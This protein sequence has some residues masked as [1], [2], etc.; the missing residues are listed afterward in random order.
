[1]S[2]SSGGFKTFC[3]TWLNAYVACSRTRHGRCPLDQ[4][5]SQF[6]GRQEFPDPFV[7]RADCHQVFNN[8]IICLG[9]AVDAVLS[10]QIIVQAEGP[11]E[12]QCVIGHGQRQ[13]FFS[14]AGRGDE[15]PTTRVFHEPVKVASTVRDG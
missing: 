15:N 2:Y 6:L 5:G 3:R 1:M 12:E 4:R 9:Y 7:N 13:S 14:C 11:V 8:T 10:L